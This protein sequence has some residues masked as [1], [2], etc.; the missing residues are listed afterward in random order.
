ML[1][2]TAIVTSRAR[3][4]AKL[5]LE[6]R[7]R[8]D[9]AGELDPRGPRRRGQMDDGDA[10]LPQDESTAEQGEDDKERVQ[11][12]HRI[13]KRTCR[14]FPRFS[15]ASSPAKG[16]WVAAGGAAPAMP[17]AIPC[18]CSCCL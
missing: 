6:R 8:T 16:L 10:W 9:P 3:R 18:A 1:D 2:E 13:G 11:R 14:H 15:S 4:A 7:Q 5:V 12:D 17:A